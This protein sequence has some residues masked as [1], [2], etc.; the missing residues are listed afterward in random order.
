MMEVFIWDLK[1]TI[2]MKILNMIK[3]KTLTNIHP[4]TMEIA[5][6]ACTPR[7]PGQVAIITVRTF[8][9]K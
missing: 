8:S 6:I 5:I 3:E 1:C 7:I 4:L 9:K 2:S